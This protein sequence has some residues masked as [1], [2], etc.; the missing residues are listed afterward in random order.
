MIKRFLENMAR[1]FLA[2]TDS[3]IAVVFSD[4]TRLSNREGPAAVE[5]RFL[6]KQ[7]ELNTLVFG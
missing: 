7:A 1:D 3:A 6:N 2:Q 5:V 4:D